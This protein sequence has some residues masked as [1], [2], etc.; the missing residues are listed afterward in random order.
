VALAGGVAANTQIGIAAVSSGGGVIAYR[1]GAADAGRRLAWFDRTG[2]EID[3]APSP[4]RIG[5]WGPSIS[6]DSRRV[7]LTRIVDGNEDVWILETD[8]GAPKRI[9]FDAARDIGP[10]WSPDGARI[11]FMSTRTG[12]GELFQRA[13]DGTGNEVPLQ[14]SAGASQPSDWSLD[15]RFLLYRKQDART[16]YD[17]WA[18]PLV[19]D[20]TAF[21]VVQTTSNERDAQ[22]SP[23][24]K[25][26]AYESDESGQFE[27]YVR[28]FP[29]PGAAA[30]V[31]TGG[32][33]Q[34]RWSRDGTEL[35]YIALDD[36]LMSVSIRIDST[37][38]TVVASATRPLFM[39]LVGGAVGVARQQ[40]AVT[41]DGQR[42][43]MNVVAPRAT[44]IALLVNW[45]SR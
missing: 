8:R 9:T 14:N 1:T 20:R 33:A 23:D 25:W 40:Y 31:S 30:L 3:V 35:F 5:D 22:F 39:T 42:F 32:G 43:V 45:R 19:G 28:P 34:V 21:P 37:R 15:G 29:G 16:R 38:Q 44:P 4:D 27:I 2:S 18:L 41:R 6:P 12:G 26:I 24:G 17:I 10:V 7:A 36:R 13:A 11:V